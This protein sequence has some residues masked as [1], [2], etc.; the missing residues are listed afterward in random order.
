MKLERIELQP[1][2]NLDRYPLGAGEQNLLR[3]TPAVIVSEYLSE[4]GAFNGPV[5]ERAVAIMKDGYQVR[6]IL[7]FESFFSMAVSSYFQGIFLWPQY[8]YKWL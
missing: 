3:M 2:P 6:T 8:H 1:Y 5:A 4:V 7:L